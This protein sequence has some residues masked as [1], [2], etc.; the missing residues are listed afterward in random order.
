[1][2]NTELLIK[3]L[4]H[5]ARLH[6]KQGANGLGLLFTNAAQEIEKLQ[7]ENA[8]LKN[9]LENG[10][11]KDIVWVTRDELGELGDLREENA[12][13]KKQSQW[14]SVDDELPE[15]LQKVITSITNDSVEGLVSEAVHQMEGEFICVGE[16]ASRRMRPSVGVTHWMPLPT[17]P[18]GE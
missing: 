1:M 14:I 10:T 16:I 4:L 5:Q 6:N 7:S 2:S 11:R 8:E 17:P 18:E 9:L 13:L 15:V 3:T 12:E